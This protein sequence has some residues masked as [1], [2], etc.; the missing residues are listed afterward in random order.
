MYQIPGQMSLHS[1]ISFCLVYSSSNGDY[2]ICFKPS[3]SWL[4]RF[5]FEK[6]LKKIIRGHILVSTASSQ[7]TSLELVKRSCTCQLSYA[8]NTN[9][10][11]PPPVVDMT[12]NV[13]QIKQLQESFHTLS[14][15]RHLCHVIV[16]EE[17]S[18]QISFVVLINFTKLH[19]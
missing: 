15:K 2:T 11:S 4:G 12:I 13:Q 5:L 1:S 8:V 14:L 3:W 18:L 17:H 9:I 10:F 19:Q 6:L 16:S 7:T